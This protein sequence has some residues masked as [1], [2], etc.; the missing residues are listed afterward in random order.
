M[1]STKLHRID[2]IIRTCLTQFDLNL[3]DLTVMTEAATGPYLY[4]PILAALAG[5]RRTYAL[6]A[7]SRFGTKEQVKELTQEAAYRWGVAERIEVLFKKTRQT[8]GDSDIVT[9]S[10]FVRPIDREMVSW[11]KPTAVVSLMWEP[12]EFRGDD[13]DLEA[14][15]EHDVLIMGADESHLYPYS[16]YIAMKLLFE[17][18]LEGFGTKVL[19]LG[20]QTGLAKGIFG[21]FQRVGMEIAWF[22]DGQEESRPYS[23]FPQ[24]FL[25]NG[26]DF[27]VLIAAEH[28]NSV[29]LLGKDGLI[30]Y[31][32]I[33][34]INRGLCIGAISGNLDIQGLRES[35]LH[36]APAVL[37][38][39][40][41]MSYQAADLGPLPVLEL[42]ATG[43]KVGEEMARARLQGMGIEDAKAAAI[44]NSRAL[45][46][47]AEIT[48]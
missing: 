35:G 18:G 10:G 11:M 2:K 36:Y 39:F 46:F 42:Y 3:R 41:Y 16:G 32:Q 7:D 48:L 31:D 21:H 6:T 14:C 28:A 5:A 4:T 45:D 30:S 34:D 29:C 17:L 47:P 23:E 40:R 24:Y 13:I 25:R 1:D 12:W 44:T 15:R 38:P 26:R 27:D 9:N 19:L 43:L 8:V 22:G 37:R 20:G 33:V